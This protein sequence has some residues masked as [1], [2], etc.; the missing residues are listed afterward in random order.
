M[1]SSGGT[2]FWLAHLKLG[3]TMPNK[4]LSIAFKCWKCYLTNVVITL[5]HD[6][7]PPN[8]YACR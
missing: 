6:V 2:A 4:H 5:L 8:N 1:S 7:C 3:L